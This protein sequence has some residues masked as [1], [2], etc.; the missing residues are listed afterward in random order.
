MS[1]TG[2]S[3]KESVCC[4]S[5]RGLARG[6][7]GKEG[8]VRKKEVG[9][10]ERS[11]RRCTAGASH[12]PRLHLL[13]RWQLLLLLLLG[14]RPWVLSVLLLLNSLCPRCLADQPLLL[15]LLPPLLRLLRRAGVCQNPG[16]P[17]A[18]RC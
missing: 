11:R 16:Q 3:R 4:T 14:V 2:A 18:P 12:G 13:N 8:E 10:E 1:H 17:A 6:Q 9:E 7:G 15:L 5:R